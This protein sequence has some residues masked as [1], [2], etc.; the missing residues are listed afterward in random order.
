MGA[1]L[2]VGTRLAS[3]VCTTEVVVI[4]A[5]GEVPELT[6][7]GEPAIPAGSDRPAPGGVLR[8]GFATGSQVG[9]RYIDAAATIEVLCT[10]AGEGTIAAAGVPLTVRASKPLPSSD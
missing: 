1:T 8:D 5:S 4:R 6:I 9:K 2:K 10:K 3:A 7:G